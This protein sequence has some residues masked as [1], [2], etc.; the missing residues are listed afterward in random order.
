MPADPLARLVVEIANAGVTTRCPVGLAKDAAPARAAV[1]ARYEYAA[2]I[3]AAKVT[4]AAPVRDCLPV[5]TDIH[6]PACMTCNATARPA[7]TG[8]KVSLAVPVLAC[9]KV[10][11]TVRDPDCATTLN[12][13]IPV[14]YWAR[15]LP[16]M[17]T[18]GANDRSEYAPTPGA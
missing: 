18:R 16:A 8:R 6:V 1:H 4:V 7:R 14:T 10:V 17:V 3:P 13:L 9:T 5:A 11:G 15:T 2:G 12:V